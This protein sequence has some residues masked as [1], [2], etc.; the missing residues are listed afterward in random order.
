M[1]L[2]E[3]KQKKLEEIKKQISM[4]SD[5]LIDESEFPI[6]YS[7]KKKSFGFTNIIAISIILLIIVSTIVIIL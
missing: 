4:E 5:Y 6:I 3:N 2:T 7:T 1:K